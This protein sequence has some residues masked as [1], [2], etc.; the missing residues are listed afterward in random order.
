LSSAFEK[1]QLSGGRAG[2]AI[3]VYSLMEW[4][5]ESC[6]CEPVIKDLF[7]EHYF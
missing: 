3:G 2:G 1:Q 5:Q 4:M 7:L 6:Q